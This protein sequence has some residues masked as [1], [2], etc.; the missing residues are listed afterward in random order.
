[1]LKS[2][3]KIVAKRY[4]HLILGLNAE[5]YHHM[6]CGGRRV[7]SGFKDRGLF[8]TFYPFCI[9]FIWILFKRRDY[10][11]VK[12]EIGRILRSHSFNSSV[13]VENILE[14]DKKIEVVRD[15]SKNKVQILNSYEANKSILDEFKFLAK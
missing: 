1:M 3:L 12:L 5:E 7:S 6:N 15:I 8:E 13:K 11:L 4:C 2:T 14:E 9:F 10:E